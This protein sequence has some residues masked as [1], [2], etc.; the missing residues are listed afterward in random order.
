M[1]QEAEAAHG[2]ERPLHRLQ[3][4]P[5]L[6]LHA[7]HPRARGGRRRRLRDREHDVRGVRLA[8]EA[9]PEPHGLDLPRLHGVPEMPQRR[10]R[11]GRGRQGRGAARRADGGEVPAL[12]P[13]PRPAPRPLRRLRRPARTTRPA[14]TSRPSR[15]RTRACAARRTA[16]TSPSGAAA[17]GL[18]YGC[19]ELSQL[20]LL[21]LGAARSREACPQC[22]NPYL[23]YRERKSGNVFA[24]DKAGCGFEKPPGE[25]PPIVEIIPEA[26]ARAEPA[27]AGKGKSKPRAKAVRAQGKPKA[28]RRGAAKASQG[29]EGNPSPARPMK[30]PWEKFSLPAGG[31]GPAPAALRPEFVRTMRA[32]FGPLVERVETFPAGAHAWLMAEVP[33]EG[34]LSVFF[35]DLAAGSSRPARSGSSS[36]RSPSPTSSRFP[37]LAGR[38]EGGPLGRPRGQ[39]GRGLLR[40]A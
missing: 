36:R 37:T 14:S 29:R 22:G 33:S 17:S 35:R 3:R 23:L 6:H 21:A 20:R 28:P 39:Q 5:G 31:A 2:Q 16:A 15:S 40:R 12:R 1:R 4:V 8:D 38:A 19:V 24:C 11:R 27:A 18:F 30:A 13:R 34:S 10:Q 9:A 26:A 32:V 7:E 25:L